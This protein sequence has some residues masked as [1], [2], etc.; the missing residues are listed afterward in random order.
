MYICNCMYMLVS[1]NDSAPTVKHPPQSSS[2]EEYLVRHGSVRR[3][4]LPYVSSPPTWNLAKGKV[5]LSFWEEWPTG[6]VSSI[7]SCLVH[8][9]HFASGRSVMSLHS[10][11]LH[12]MSHGISWKKNVSNEAQST[13]TSTHLFILPDR[14]PPNPLLILFEKLGR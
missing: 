8:P 4:H 7:G 13:V 14:V 12:G 6:P 9:S 11:H 5:P 2:S 1:N 10:K 3:I